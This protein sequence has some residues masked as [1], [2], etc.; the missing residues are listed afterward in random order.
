RGIERPFHSHIGPAELM[1][2]G[3]IVCVTGGAG[4]IGS[5]LVRKLLQRGHVVHATL[6]NFDDKSKVQLL[7]SLDGADERLHLFKAEIYHRRVRSS[8]TWMR[9]RLPRRHP[10]LS[11]S[12]RHPGRIIS[13]ACAYKDTT[14]AS[15][16]AARSIMSACE[17]SGSVRRVIYTGS[18]MSAS[19]FSKGTV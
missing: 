14:E 6:R 11:K 4:Y 12:W 8:N 16:A 17:R 19:P 10:S 9:V 5:W 18:A 3:S 1:A 15:L 7:K 2:K 13:P